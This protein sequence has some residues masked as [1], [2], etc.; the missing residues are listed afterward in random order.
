[1]PLSFSTK[2]KDVLQACKVLEQMS[3]KVRNRICKVTAIGFLPVMLAR[4]NFITLHGSRQTHRVSRRYEVLEHWLTYIQT[5]YIG[6]NVLFAPPIWNVHGMD[7]RTTNLLEG[8]LLR[9]TPW[10]IGRD[11]DFSAIL[12]KS[13][14]NNSQLQN[15]LVLNFDIK[16]TA[17]VNLIVQ[18]ATTEVRIFKNCTY[19]S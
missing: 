18:S 17:Q 2:I 8:T 14:C 9:A 3:P 5:T 16:M 4:Q 12:T 1:M 13:N 7:T 15:A 11:I 19:K 6:N 10:K